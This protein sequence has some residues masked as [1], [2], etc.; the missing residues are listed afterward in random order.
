MSLPRAFESLRKEIMK[1]FCGRRKIE[2]N[3]NAIIQRLTVKYGSL[4]KR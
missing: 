1:K 3:G 2:N 4:K